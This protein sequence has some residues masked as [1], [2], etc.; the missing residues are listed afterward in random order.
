MD[1]S[2]TTKPQRLQ[3]LIPVSSS[4]DRHPK[5]RRRATAPDPHAPSA[6]CTEADHA[7]EQDHTRKPATRLGRPRPTAGPKK[8]LPRT[9]I[10]SLMELQDNRFPPPL[11]PSINADAIDGRHEAPPPFLFSPPTPSPYKIRPN[12]LPL[13]SLPHPSSLPVRAPSLTPSLFS[14]SPPV[15]TIAAVRGASPET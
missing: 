4:Q 5:P 14:P 3:E 13:F 1:P 10:S 6:P 15:I 2:S 8:P 7:A 11:P 12:S 9:S